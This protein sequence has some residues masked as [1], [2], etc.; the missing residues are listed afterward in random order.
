MAPGT[1]L[2]TGSGALTVE[3]RNGAG[4]TNSESGAIALQ[5]VAAGLVAV[6]NDGPTA[7]SDIEL[8]SV[9]TSGVQSYADPNGITTVSGTTAAANPI[10]FYD[11]VVLNDG[12]SVDAGYGTV[13]FAGSGLQT[14]QS[15][16]GATLG[17]VLHNGTGTLQLTSDLT[18]LGRLTNQSGTFDANNQPVTVAGLTT[19][20]GGMY[21][22]GTAP[23]NFTGGLVIL[24]GV[25][26]SSTGSMSISGGMLLASGQLSGVGT[27]DAL[28][29]FDGTVAPAVPA[30]GC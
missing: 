24:A 25:F 27:I 11:S 3:L 6:V 8:G 29:T 16:T 15:G 10:T 2:D 21:L 12:V 4:L 19:V 17:N 30:Q 1:A 5:S 22:A 7:G 9:M 14:L 26:S 13:N 28:T 23:Q 18:V 20:A